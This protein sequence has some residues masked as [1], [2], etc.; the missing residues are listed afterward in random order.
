MEEVDVVNPAT[1]AAAGGVAADGNS[2]S[3]SR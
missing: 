3:D 1:A 2:G